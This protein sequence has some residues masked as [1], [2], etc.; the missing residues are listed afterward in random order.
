MA[1]AN[2]WNWTDSKK[3]EDGTIL[4]ILRMDKSAVS[5]IMMARIWIALSTAKLLH[6]VW[7]GHVPT[8]RWLLDWATDA[9]A[10][11]SPR[12]V[13]IGCL[14]QNGE[15]LDIAGFGT[16]ATITFLG[17]IK[18]QP[19]FKAEVGF[20]FLPFAHRTML[21]YQFAEMMIDWGFRT[22]NL[23]VLYGTTPKPNKMA[24]RFAERVGFQVVGVLPVYG[25][26][27]K[28]DGTIEPCDY[29]SAVMT[30]EQWG[31]AKNMIHAEDLVEV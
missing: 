9:N 30:R 3:L 29:Q 7:P 13:V 15:K 27:M 23:Q 19:R 31:L 26:W 5:E 8:L 18:E 10:D 14:I 20:A 28:E 25:P 12:N 6:I 2:G 11:G 21:P 4:H 17:N 16:I 22:L 24:C 1:D